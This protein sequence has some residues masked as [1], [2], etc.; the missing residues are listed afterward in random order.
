MHS[1]SDSIYFLD[2]WKGGKEGSKSSWRKMAAR[3]RV[4]TV[5]DGITALETAVT[6]Q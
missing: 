3:R 6:D 5:D 4:E 1:D 2:V